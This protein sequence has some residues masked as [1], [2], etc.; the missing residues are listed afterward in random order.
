MYYLLLFHYNSSYANTSQDYV[1]RLVIRD[2]VLREVVRE[3]VSVFFRGGGGG[4]LLQAAGV[5]GTYYRLP[6]PYEYLLSLSWR[7]L[8][9]KSACLSYAQ[10]L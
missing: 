3:V 10:M 6:C 8:L 4:Y 2:S 9:N 1:V 7:V 5:A